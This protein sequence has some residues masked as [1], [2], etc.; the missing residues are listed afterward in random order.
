MSR[1]PTLSPWDVAAIGALGTAGF[2]LSYDALE[3]MARAIHIRGQLSYLFPVVIDGFTAYGVR[4]LMILREAPWTARAYTWALFAGATGTSVWANAVHAVRLNE[5]TV[6]QE[7]LR[8]GDTVVGGLSMIAP[9]ALAG[10]VHLGI[11]A[12]RHGASQA[13]PKTASASH[14]TARSTLN[15]AEADAEPTSRAE[16][17]A[18][19][20]SLAASRTVRA[21]LEAAPTRAATSRTAEEKLR[22]HRRG[23]RLRERIANRIRR[24]IESTGPDSP[25]PNTRTTGPDSPGPNTRTTGPDSPGP[26]TRT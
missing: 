18:E 7:V 5:Q 12:S 6:G 25:G 3:Q 22:A 2:A 1:R 26:N 11:I 23:S 9:L 14:H 15:R 24:R 19:S 10:A 13:G 8:L 17:A 20:R 16:S 21:E 4:A